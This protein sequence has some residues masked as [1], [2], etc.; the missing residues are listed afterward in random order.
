MRTRWGSGMRDMVWS[1]GCGWDDER[2]KVTKLECSTK[3]TLAN[4]S[5]LRGLYIPSPQPEVVY[6][7]ERPPY[8]CL[9]VPVSAVCALL[10]EGDI[11]YRV[12]ADKTPRFTRPTHTSVVSCTETLTRCEC[13]EK[14]SFVSRWRNQRTKML[15]K[16]SHQESM[17]T[18][19]KANHQKNCVSFL[20]VY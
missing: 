12:Y 5:K 3:K 4:N 19:C 7:P 16:N 18:T 6:S 13:T 20:S 14:Y 9:L 15:W 10:E 11:M 8:F 17:Y 2:K 1:T